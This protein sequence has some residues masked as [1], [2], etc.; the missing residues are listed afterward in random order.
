MSFLTLTLKVNS[1]SLS[2]QLDRLYRS[3]AALR[4]RKSWLAHVAGGAAF[5]EV[6]IGANSGGW[7]A[8][9]HIIIEST[10]WDQK[11]IAQEWYAVTGDSH[12]VD[13]SR[14]DDRGQKVKYAAKYGA[15][16]LD[17]SVLL[18]PD[19]LD[20]AVTALKGR[21]VC[22]TFGSWRGLKLEKREPDAAVWRP[23]CTLDHLVRQAE[24]GDPTAIRI[25]NVIRRVADVASNPIEDSS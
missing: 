13:I 8:H 12:I 16:A 21:R 6:K 18:L 15:K 11:A 19:R 17:R 14:L 20:E 5:V 7:H 9:L 23:L 4:R 2:K 22:L 24:A 10:F 25:Y 1:L 3:F